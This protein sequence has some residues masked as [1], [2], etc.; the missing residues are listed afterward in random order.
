MTH[1][2]SPASIGP[3]Q[4][5]NRIVIAPMCQFSAAAGQAGDWHMMHLGT[6]ALSGA[7]LLILES[8]AVTPEGRITYG[9]LGLWDDLTEAALARVIR[10]VRLHSKMPIGIQLSHAGRKASTGFAKGPAFGPDDTRGWRTV[11]PSALPLTKDGP[12]PD[13]LDLEGINRIVTAFGD[14]A[15]RA[16]RMGLQLIEL[17]GAH[18]FLMHQFMSPITNR[19]TDDYG[20]SLENRMR[21]TLR[22]FDAVK[23][24]V[25]E[26]VAVGIRISATDW[27][28][29][30]WDVDDSIELAKALDARGCSY[31]HVSGGGLDP[32][33][34]QLPPLVPG[35]QLPY[36]ETIR[37][38]V[39][40][41]VVGV[42]LITTPQQ[43]EAALA[44]GKADLIALG[45]GILYNPR[46][47]WHAAAEL[48][49]TV[50]A[51]FQYAGSAPQG[52][53]GLFAKAS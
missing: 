26:N 12:L 5:D 53:K 39:Q 41:P 28:E 34:Q 16:A 6:L 44:E 14:A 35:Y 24:A 27:V 45:R 37:Q 17:H 19:R 38:H 13:E 20:G 25:P 48:G 30:G 46:W 2:F 43:A 52:S 22:I 29:G 32:E 9:D 23:A 10:S 50:R 4:L 51:P 49:A 11:A 40:M 47:P 18:G 31:I 36:A 42:G 21:L 15:A 8:T 7:G 33:H 3:L 1:L